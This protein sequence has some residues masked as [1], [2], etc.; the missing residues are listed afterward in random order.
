MAAKTSRQIKG[1]CKSTP[2]AF[3]VSGVSSIMAPIHNQH[4]SALSLDLSSTQHMPGPACRL[5]WFPAAAAVVSQLAWAAPLRH[6]ARPQACSSTPG[7]SHENWN[8]KT[9][10][11]NHTHDQCLFLLQPS[12]QHKHGKALSCSTRHTTSRQ[13]T[14]ECAPIASHVSGHW[15]AIARS[16]D[17]NCASAVPGRRVHGCNIHC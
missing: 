7:S 4:I 6:K 16:F 14:P 12:P 17:P 8:L 5:Q 3:L 1:H 9:Q 13:F 2:Q 11:T 10:T 15:H